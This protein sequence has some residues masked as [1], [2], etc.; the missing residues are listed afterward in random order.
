MSNYL[1]AKK[2]W[3]VSTPI[4]RRVL[5]LRK[6]APKKIMELVRKKQYKELELEYK[7]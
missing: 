4:G 5:V 7:K 2:L 3:E 6:E 1:I